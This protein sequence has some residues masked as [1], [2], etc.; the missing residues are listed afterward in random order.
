MA[1][2]LIHFS[3]INFSDLLDSLTRRS[4]AVRI[5]PIA[6]TSEEAEFIR[7]EINRVE[8]ERMVE[9]IGGKEKKKHQRH[10]RLISQIYGVE[11]FTNN[12]KLV[13]EKK[14]NATDVV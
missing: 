2:Y 3:F 11:H 6:V 8:E 1:D 7:R 4:K 14:R 5:I 10:P 12:P 13:M 9:K